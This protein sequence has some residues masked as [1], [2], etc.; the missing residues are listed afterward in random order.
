[1][2]SKLLGNVTEASFLQPSKVLF[3]NDF[4]PLGIIIAV[5]LLQFSNVPTP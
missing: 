4:T 2:L 3:S 5:K 1:M